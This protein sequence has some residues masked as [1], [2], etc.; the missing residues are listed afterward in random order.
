MKSCNELLSQVT[1]CERTP[2]SR[3]LLRLPRLR[4]LGAALALRP[5]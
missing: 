1:A 5:F 4:G 3:Q 2:M